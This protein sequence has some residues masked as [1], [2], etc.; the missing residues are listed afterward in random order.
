MQ[1]AFAR[2]KSV[3]PPAHEGSFQ[4]AL[5]CGGAHKGCG[6]PFLIEGRAAASCQ[7]HA[8]QRHPMAVPNHRLFWLPDTVPNSP[9]ID[10]RTPDLQPCLEQGSSRP[11]R[12]NSFSHR[13]TS[14]Q[15]LL[16]LLMCLSHPMNSVWLGLLSQG[17]E[18]HQGSLENTE[19]GRGGSQSAGPP[20]GVTW[21]T[22]FW[23]VLFCWRKIQL[24]SCHGSCWSM[25]S[26]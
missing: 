26:A 3:Y 5:S 8:Q 7:N 2:D 20:F 17:R 18:A 16:Q 4:P 24:A 13:L 15:S 19:T 22:N 1:K 25:A 14:W 6:T 11:L 9:P 12:P 21:E 23:G 10:C